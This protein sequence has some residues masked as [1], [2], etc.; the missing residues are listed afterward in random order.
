M[1]IKCFIHKYNYR[2]LKIKYFYNNNNQK[3]IN[4]NKIK[5]F[6]LNYYKKVKLNKFNLSNHRKLKIS[7]LNLN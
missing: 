5:L 4:S 7:Y 6:N 1:K 3:K 2:I